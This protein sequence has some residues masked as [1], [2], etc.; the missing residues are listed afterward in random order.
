MTRR[1]RLIAPEVVQVS[2]MDCGP[3]S[4]KCFLDGAG[5]SVSYGRLREACQ[6]D[7]DGT[8]IDTLEEVAIHLGVDA[9]QV[10]VPPEHIL[11]Q[12]ERSLPS[13]VVVSL[14]SGANHFVVLWRRYG[15]LV[16]VMDPASG[17]RWPR[18]EQFLNEIY[19]H[20]Y[21]VPASAWRKWAETEEFTL[22]LRSRL[23][24][25]GSSG[26][27]AEKLINEA[28]AES[29]WR[30]I[31][32][33]EAA[34]RMIENLV[35]AGA[36]RRGRETCRLLAT[37]FDRASSQSDG[38]RIVPEIYWSV[39]PAP[40]AGNDLEVLI[41]RGAVVVR[42]RGDLKRHAAYKTE[43][44]TSTPLSPELKAAAE[45]PPSRPLRQIAGLLA[46][47]GAPVSLAVILGLFASGFGVVFE[48]L[49]FRGLLGLGREL[50]LLTQ[51]LE[52]FGA[53]LVFSSALLLLELPLTD[54][55]MR[56]GR[57]AEA[58]LRVRFLRKLPRLGDRYFQ[59]RL[60]SDM[61]E[62]SHS[63]Y[64]LRLLPGTGGQLVRLAFTLA[65]TMAGIWWLDPGSAPIALLAAATGLALPI[66]TQPF[67]AES[68]LRVRT[69]AAGLSRF[70][71]DALLGIVPIRTHGA[72]R[73]IRREHEALLV[74]W[75]RS[76]LKLQRKVVSV[77]GLQ[78]LFAFGFACW[79]VFS[80]AGRV[81]DAA[82]SLLLIY[83]ALS[84]PALGQ[85][86]SLTAL[87]YPVYRNV[88]LRLLEPLGAPEED[89]SL[90]TGVP[91][92]ENPT[93]DSDAAGVEVV[94]NQV[95]VLAAGQTILDGI[96][97]RI[98]PG[99][100]VGIVG[101]SGAGKSSLVGL[102]LGWHRPASGCVA[103]DGRRLDG[104]RLELLRRRT[105]WV[106]PTVQVWNRTLLENLGYGAPDNSISRVGEVID[107]SGLTT[108]LK[109]LPEG[110]QSQLGEGGALVSGG[111]GQRV[112]L[113]RGMMRSNA[114][115]VILDE[116]FRGID[117]EQRSRL[118]GNARSIWKDATLLYVTHDAAEAAG[119]DRILVV[120]EGRVVEDGKPEHLLEA[121]GPY[122]RMV[123]A[124]RESR[125]RF[126]SKRIWRRLMF[127][128]GSLMERQD[129]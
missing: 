68:D 51:R 40:Q 113:A 59:S 1:R 97:L 36:F 18:C 109:K 82:N 7:L 24:G 74:E 47:D 90:K 67:L 102:L 91:A 108:V 50:G 30:S 63:L 87:Q 73:A 117:R 14:P 31:A 56:M 54:A 65:L 100:H 48:A 123:A 104:Q 23:R 128:N 3:A 64:I 5:V 75:T 76:S 37:L 121:R 60:T 16:Q 96:S 62:R 107:Q 20:N 72:E 77:E 114:R 52:A 71:L 124:E 9:E 58:R 34:T 92:E 78:S 103:V 99:E 110:L 105:V 84:I 83:W 53:L 118:L 69:H 17:R 101:R 93:N 119:F 35:R 70:Y 57:R 49:L 89:G 8:S 2:A 39:S 88:L 12:G 25:I 27:E 127:R 106:D 43:T 29:G 44:R 94:L 112:R 26:A 42:S 79:I 21:P 41:T 15:P 28:F 120:D 13:I 10:I 32:A 126:V 95:G 38:V 6:T 129:D 86:L 125:R 45:E 22:P 80:Y 11:M 4:L 115:L 46:A 98:A 116:A 66:V 61:A 55:L 81:A 19:I 33:L 85:Q 122:Y 111:E